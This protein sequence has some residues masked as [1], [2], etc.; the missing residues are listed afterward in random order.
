VPRPAHFFGG[1]M[2]VN[3]VFAAL[4]GLAHIGQHLDA[5]AWFAIAVIVGAN[6]AAVST[7]P[8]HRRDVTQV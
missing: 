3:P 1:F 5:L 4:V 7:T 6:T 2:S 8:G